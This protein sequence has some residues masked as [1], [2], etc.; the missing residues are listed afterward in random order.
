MR[1]SV[2]PVRGGAGKDQAVTAHGHVVRGMTGARSPSASGAT[3]GVSRNRPQRARV[4]W[5]RARDGSA[6]MHAHF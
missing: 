3:D 1:A 2:G 5:R 6:L 4:W